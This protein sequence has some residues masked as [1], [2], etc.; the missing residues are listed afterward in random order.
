MA[1]SPDSADTQGSRRRTEV[2]E[3]VARHRRELADRPD[4]SQAM[5]KLSQSSSRNPTRPMGSEK[6][7]R[8]PPALTLAIGAGAVLAMLVCVATAV[9]VLAGNLWLQNQLNDPGT[10]VQQYYA[11]LGQKNYDEAYSYF[12]KRL[13]GEIGSSAYADTFGSYDAVDGVVDRYVVTSSQV[14][15]NSA[16]I[17]VTVVRR[18]REMAQVQTLRLVKEN[19]DW[20]IDNIVLGGDVPIPSPTP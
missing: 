6:Q 11:A 9:T 16:T 8:R 18:G 20:R 5:R 10:T 17:T 7:R 2:A 4:I 19:G 14:N 15:G 1:N 3:L 12:S 13:Q